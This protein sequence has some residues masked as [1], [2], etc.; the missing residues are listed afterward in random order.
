MFIVGN[1]VAGNGP[2][3][4]T[5]GYHT[6]GAQLG[7]IYAANDNTDGVSAYTLRL[8][9]AQNISLPDYLGRERLTTLTN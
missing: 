7:T 2:A 6:N 3:N 9:G 8:G 1:R 5:Q 4:K